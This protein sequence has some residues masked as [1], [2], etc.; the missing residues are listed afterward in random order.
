[1]ILSATLP[2]LRLFLS[3]SSN[4]FLA[5]LQSF[6]MPLDI[7]SGEAPGRA[8]YRMCEP[9]LPGLWV[10]RP[11]GLWF[12]LKIATKTDVSFSFHQHDLFV[13]ASPLNIALQIFISYAKG[14]RLHL[15][16]VLSKCL[17]DTP[18]HKFF[19]WVLWAD[20]LNFLLEFLFVNFL[21]YFIINLRFLSFGVS[22]HSY[23]K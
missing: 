11:I 8:I 7:I 6:D 4:H 12:K 2:F 20:F 10:L 1:M 21:R 15:F 3:C 18:V 9:A 13:Q 14:R 19:L 17:D 16:F 5:F 23:I 22:P